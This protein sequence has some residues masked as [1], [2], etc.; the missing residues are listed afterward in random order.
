MDSIPYRAL[1]AGWVLA[2]SIGGFNWQHNTQHT[3]GLPL[4][5]GTRL[6]RTFQSPTRGQAASLV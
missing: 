3:H 5:E 1:Q 6:K 2:G 4:L